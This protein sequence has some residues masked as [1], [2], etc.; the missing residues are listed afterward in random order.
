[1]IDPEGGILT[2]TAGVYKQEGDRGQILGA[3]PSGL[4]FDASNLIFSGSITSPNT[5]IISVRATDVGN[6]QAD[7]SFE[8]KIVDRPQK[9]ALDIFKEIISTIAPIVGSALLSILAYQWRQYQLKQHREFQHPFA[10]EVHGWLNLAYPDFTSSPGQ[11]FARIITMILQIIKNPPSGIDIPERDRIREVVEDKESVSL[12]MT[13]ED[14]DMRKKPAERTDKTLSPELYSQVR[15]YCYAVCVAKA[16]YMTPGL[17]KPTQVCGVQLRWFLASNEIQMSQFELQ[18]ENIVRKVSKE[19][20]QFP[21]ELEP[22]SPKPGEVKEGGWIGWAKNCRSTLVR[23]EESDQER[24]G[25]EKACC[26]P[27]RN[28]WHDFRVENQYTLFR[29]R[30]REILKMDPI[31]YPKTLDQQKSDAPE[32]SGEAK[33]AENPSRFMSSP[34]VSG[35]RG[36]QHD[37]LELREITPPPSAQSEHQDSLTV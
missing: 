6:L 35:R 21:A 28:S 4:Q 23:D 14:L 15:Y 18:T 11:D 29:T 2:T 9:T 30:E 26:G 17:L 1:M 32:P 25:I 34:S 3:L 7:T 13:I 22:K 16:I 24:S 8:L 31:Q 37:D 10:S 27:L 12:M 33:H 19:I 20:K 5:T 36:S